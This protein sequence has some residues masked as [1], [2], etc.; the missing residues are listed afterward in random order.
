[1]NMHLFQHSIAR[2]V[3]YLAQADRRMALHAWR[4]QRLQGAILYFHG[5]QSHAGWLWSVGNAFANLGIAFYA[6]DREGCGISSGQ[7]HGFPDVRTLH[8]DASAA[9]E[10][11]RREVPDDVPLCLFGHCLGGS[12]LAAIASCSHAELPYDN[13]VI[14]S[15]WLG[16]MHDR[17][18]EQ[19]RAGIDLDD[20]QTLW[21]AGLNPDDFTANPHLAEFIRN[22]ALATTHLHHRERKKLLALEKVYLAPDARP[23]DAPS[24]FICANK[25][26]LV[27]VNATV[28]HF[29]R[30]CRNGSTLLVNQDKHYLFFTPAMGQVVQFTA[31]F[32]KANGRYAYD[33]A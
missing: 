26:P 10:H 4:P 7:K 21:D 13:L 31:D 8:E 25:D 6:L 23:I 27:D 28:G 19:E 9:I 17:L 14:C 18:S 3:H 24:L 15:A 29:Q 1:M 32:V 11:I 33:A 16:K 12:V 22:D 5:L 2:E 20:R 30:L